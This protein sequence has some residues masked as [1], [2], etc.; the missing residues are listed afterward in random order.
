MVYEMGK[1]YVDRR[2]F[3]RNKKK[4]VSFESNPDL[5]RT[6]SD[7]Y[8][9]CVPCITSLYEQLAEGKTEIRL[10]EAYQC[11]KIVVPLS[12]MEEC[13]RFLCEF[14]ACF[15][16]KNMSIKGRFG[17]DDSTKNTKVIVFNAE[18]EVERDHLYEELK[19]C[20]SQTYPESMVSYHR[21]C[22]ELYHELLGDW[23]TWSETESIKNPGMVKATME[24]IRRILF[25]EKEHIPADSGS[26]V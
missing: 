9:R 5:K 6:K 11:W 15:L 3:A 17:S 19:A 22:A 23:K 4:W 13:T 20:A 7:I 25:W 10:G 18:S 21:A 8:G 16:K 14:E 1:L 2:Y 26:I 12:N 24:R